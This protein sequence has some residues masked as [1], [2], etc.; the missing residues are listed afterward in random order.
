MILLILHVTDT[1]SLGAFRSTFQDLAIDFWA[2]KFS[3][4]ICL[5]AQIL[6]QGQVIWSFVGNK[7]SRSPVPTAGGWLI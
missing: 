4:N 6:C 7:S 1:Q 2:S 3:Q 5:N